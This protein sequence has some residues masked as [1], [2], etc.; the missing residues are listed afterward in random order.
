MKNLARERSRV[1]GTLWTLFVASQSNDDVTDGALR[2]GLCPANSRLRSFAA[3]LPAQPTNNEATEMDRGAVRGPLPEA[4]TSTA[5]L[6]IT[7]PA[8]ESGVI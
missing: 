3:Q 8:S 1:L 4:A 5:R 6:E 7:A 2:V